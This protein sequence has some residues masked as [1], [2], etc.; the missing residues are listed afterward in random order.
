MLTER[1]KF[2]QA[3]VAAPSRPVPLRVVPDWPPPETLADPPTGSRLRM[4][5]AR[6]LFFSGAVRLAE[7]IAHRIEF[8]RAP[9]GFLSL[10][11]RVIRPRFAILCYH[12]IGRGGVPIYSGLPA[13]QFEEQM[14]YL[15]KHYR[16]L[17]LAEMLREMAE[18]WVNP[19][20]V[21]VT[22]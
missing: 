4:L 18:P 13:S 5:A 14:K 2:E 7:G 21:A 17:P 10:P 15:S 6:M 12:R 16:V 11:R 9:G 8:R 19:P 3:A 22:L 20:A 1:S